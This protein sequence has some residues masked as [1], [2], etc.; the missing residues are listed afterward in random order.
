MLWQ[1][2]KGVSRRGES[3]EEKRARKNMI[4]EEKRLRREQKKG[5]KLEFKKESELQKKEAVAR[6][7]P[8]RMR[9]L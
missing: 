5:T 4:K 8:L 7:P 2:N 9:P 3:K 1:A 6:G